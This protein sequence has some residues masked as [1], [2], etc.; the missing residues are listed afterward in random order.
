[1]HVVEQFD[2]VAQLVAHSGE[3]LRSLPEVVGHVPAVRVRRAR[4]V[5]ERRLERRGP[6]ASATRLGYLDA[7]VPPALVAKRRRV[8]RGLF[9]GAP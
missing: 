8:L 7:D 3:E 4:A 9:E 5:A 6:V 2:R 1:M